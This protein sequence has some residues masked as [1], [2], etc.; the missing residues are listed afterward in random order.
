MLE[1]A[2]GYLAGPPDPTR[3]MVGGCSPVIGAPEI[4]CRECEWSGFKEDLR[5]FAS[6]PVVLTARFLK[7]MNYANAQHAGQTRKATNVAYISHPFGVAGL[8]I[9][10]RGDEDQAIGGLLH[11]VAEDCGGEV[12]LREI[13]KNFGARV[14]AIVRGCSDSLGAKEEE[15]APWKVRKEEHIKRLYG[16]DDDILLVTAADKTHNARA[17]VTDLDMIG[18]A[19]WERFNASPL[20]I[21]WYY[22]SVYEVL[23]MRGVTSILLSPLSGSIDAMR[24]HV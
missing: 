23:K 13:K 22:E 4:S 21:L 9:E 7:A 14:E 10:A 5:I 18:S 8:I 3:F 1:V 2:Y 6:P 16:A 11:D 20:D 24:R 17:I 19:L 15:K 12:R